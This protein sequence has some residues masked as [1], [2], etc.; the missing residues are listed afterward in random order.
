MV[1]VGEEVLVVEMLLLLL[2]MLILLSLL[3]LSLLLLLLLLL[4]LFVFETRLAARDK[5]PM[6]KFKNKP[7]RTKWPKMDCLFPH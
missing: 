3:L 4:L 2:P 7:N 1:A 6:T 5:D